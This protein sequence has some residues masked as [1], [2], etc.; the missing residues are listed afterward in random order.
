MKFL[1]SEKLGPH[2]YIDNSGYLICTDAILSRTGL[3]DYIKSEIFP[4]SK[5][6][7]TVIHVD[8][9]YN[10]VFSDAAMASFENKP[11]VVEHPDEDV[12]PENCRDYSVGFVR[13]IHPGKDNGVDVM[14]STVVITDQDAI[15]Q[16]QNGDY[17]SEERR[18]GK[19][20]RSRWSPYH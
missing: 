20:C 14:M 5:D 3:Q 15:E 19:E 4:D 13:D 2:R 8:R 7:K 6:T 18:V 16:V 17:R 10:E 9:P 12:N 1:M 11:I